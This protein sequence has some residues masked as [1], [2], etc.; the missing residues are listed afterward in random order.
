MRILTGADIIEVSR[1]KKAMED[2]NFKTRVF[3]DVEIEY[4]EKFGENKYEHY[5]ARFAGKE[6]IFKA[7]SPELKNKY[8][9][10]WTNIEIQRTNSGRPVVYIVK[11]D[12]E[13]IA[14]IIEK[15]KED[16]LSIDVS[17]SHIKTHAMATATVVIK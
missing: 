16:K 13:K 8:D 3:T 17:L 9:I 4:C 1:I 14:D 15:V 6:A 11:G 7:I 5:S 12:N 2:E 10:G